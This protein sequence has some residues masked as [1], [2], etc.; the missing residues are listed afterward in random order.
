MRRMPS[1]PSAPHGS[2]GATN[3][4]F[5]LLGVALAIGL[6]AS[7]IVVSRGLERIK[8]AGDKITVKGY[9]EE[10]VVSDAGTWRGTVTVRASDMQA[11]YRELEADTARVLELLR[12]VAGEAAGGASVSPVASRPQFETGPGGAPT[13]RVMGY[14]LER[15]FELS[16]PDVALIGRVAAGASG[17]ISEGVSINSWPPQFF[18]NDLNAVKVRLIGAATRDSQQRAEQFAEGSGVTVG[19]LRSASQG[20]FQIT[21]PNSTETA[22]YGS[23]DTTTVEKVV[24]AVVTVEYS[25]ARE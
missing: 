25:V 4:G 1:H 6:V 9:A 18:Y 20:V 10:K 14:E 22:D 16:S 19:A 21:R 3:L 11:G 13:G 5:L 23:Y 12:S 17:L 15:T 24:K 2:A 7:S 8:L